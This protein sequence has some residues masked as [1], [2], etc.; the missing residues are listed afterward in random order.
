MIV[1]I[2][3]IKIIIILIIIIIIFI[4]LAGRQPCVQAGW[5]VRYVAGQLAHRLAGWLVC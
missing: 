5:L 2:I 1:M 4:I 3:R